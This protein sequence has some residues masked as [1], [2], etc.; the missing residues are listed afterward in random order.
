MAVKQLPRINISISPIFNL[1]AFLLDEINQRDKT[2]ADLQKQNKELEEQNKTFAS[3][4]NRLTVSEKKL[5][6][7]LKSLKK[8]LNT[9]TEDLQTKSG[10]VL[11][12]DFLLLYNLIILD[13]IICS[14]HDLRE[15]HYVIFCHSKK[16]IDSLFLGVAN[17]METD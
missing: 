10:L 4:H 9:Q 16:T 12:N 6:E 5:T 14:I 7:K 3:D 2:I 8:A 11:K 15:S 1:Y 13:Y 17:T